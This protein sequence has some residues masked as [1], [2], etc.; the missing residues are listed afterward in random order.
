MSQGFIDFWQTMYRNKKA[1]SGMIILAIF[2]FMAIFG[3][4]MA[5][6][7]MTVN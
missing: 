1:F 6:L 3:P 5:S 2:I 4:M 7:D